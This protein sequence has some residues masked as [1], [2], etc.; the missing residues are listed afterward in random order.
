M[1][2][3]FVV[4]QIQTTVADNI[5]TPLTIGGGTMADMFR[6]EQRGAAMAIWSL[7]PLLGMFYDWHRIAIIAINHFCRPS[8]WPC[9]GRIPERSKGLAMGFLGHNYGRKFRIIFPHTCAL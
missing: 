2:G 3:F 6:V 4:C 7:G 9:C 8:D 1:F 5:S